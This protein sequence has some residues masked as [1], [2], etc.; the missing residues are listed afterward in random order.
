[1]FDLKQEIGPAT[2]RITQKGIDRA[3]EI[4]ADL[5]IIHE[6]TYGGLVDA[7]DSIRTKILN[8]P[9]PVWIFIDNNAISAG[10]LIALA[11]DRIYMREGA[12]IGAATVVDQTGTVAPEKPQSFMRSMMRSTAEAHGMDTLVVNGKTIVRWHRD[13]NIAEAMVDKRID[14]P[15]LVDSTKLLTMTVNEA[16][17]NN[18][19]E[20]KAESIPDI[21]AKNGIT[22]YTIDRYILSSLETIISFLISPYLQGILIMIIIGGIY[23]ELQSPGIGFPSI[24]AATAAL[25]YFA[26]LYLEGLANNWEIVAFI[27]GLILVAVE[28]FALPGFGVAGISGII[29]ILLGLSFAMVDN[30]VF[31]WDMSMGFYSVLKSLAIVISS[32]TI[33]LILCLLLGKSFYENKSLRRITLLAEQK[34]SEGYVSFDDNSS[35]VGTTAIVKSMLRP[36]G[37]IVIG[38]K[39]YDA[40]SEIGYI[41]AGEQVKIVRFETGQLYVLKA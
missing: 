7:A 38:D 23:F 36:S 19:C 30:I 2:W 33:A 37:K 40:M 17:S 6:N 14:I 24:A 21:L 25:L 39:L 20:G 22:D 34:S 32:S 41:N 12:S 31:E 35:L 13:P 5:I 26:P 9:V 8:C 15:G 11:A 29:L 27:V 4:G 10:A 16:I 28:I 3:V 18:F 1:V